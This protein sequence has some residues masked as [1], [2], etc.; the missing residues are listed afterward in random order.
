MTG[1]SNGGFTEKQMEMVNN[2]WEK[3]SAFENPTVF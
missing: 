2:H 3:H 1:K